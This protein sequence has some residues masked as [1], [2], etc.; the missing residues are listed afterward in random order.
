[1]GVHPGYFEKIDL[2]IAVEGRT[3]AFDQTLEWVLDY[4]GQLFLAVP[5]HPFCFWAHKS[6]ICPNMH[7]PGVLRVDK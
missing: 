2:E 6:E 5:P 3:K 7:R 4:Q 1:M